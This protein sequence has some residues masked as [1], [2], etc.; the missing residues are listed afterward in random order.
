MQ[1][2]G[3]VSGS[4]GGSS[5]IRSII[6]Q[7]QD[8]ARSN[9]IRSSQQFESAKQQSSRAIEAVLSSSVT[10]PGTSQGLNILV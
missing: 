4:V 3:G 2:V 9:V 5:R 6:M 8:Q 1:G 10:A 7:Q